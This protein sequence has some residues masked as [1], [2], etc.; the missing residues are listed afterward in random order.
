MGIGP[1]PQNRFAIQLVDGCFNQ[2]S[3]KLVGYVALALEPNTNAVNLSYYD[4]TN[5]DL[6]YAYKEDSS[7]IW[8]TMSIDGSGIGTEIFLATSLAVDN[9]GNRHISYWDSSNE[10]LK[11]AYGPVGTGDISWQLY[12]VDTSGDVGQLA[13]LAV[14]TSGNRHISYHDND[15]EGLKYAYGPA[16]TGDISWQ[17]YKVDSSG[18]TGQFASLALDTGGNRHIAY[19]NAETPDL[20]YAYGPAGN[21]DIS[22][23]IY[24]INSNIDNAYFLSLAVDNSGN[25]H[26]S[27]LDFDLDASN[28]D[29]KYAYGPAGPGNISWQIY[30]LDDTGFAGAFPSIDINP[31]TQKPSI[32]YFKFYDPSLTN[33]ELRIAKQILDTTWEIGVLDISMSVGLNSSSY[34]K[35]DIH[36]DEHLSYT[37]VDNS[38]GASQSFGRVTYG[39][40]PNGLY[41]DACPLFTT[42]GTLE[43]FKEEKPAS[44]VTN[45]T[46][47]SFNQTNPTFQQ[48]FDKSTTIVPPCPSE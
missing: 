37:E 39:L 30:N 6:R 25:R 14:D 13:S 24:N 12:S 2:T 19:T 33:A 1:G 41:G 9:S 7:N 16:G 27:Y 38:Q 32:S 11:Y 48:P 28:F 18:D 44:F 45:H 42:L 3:E 35:F 17:I 31:N 47:F 40:N 15:N 4:S 21:S 10:D 43:V 29:L 26:I 36:G 8:H 23:Q 5:Q 22:W 34:F 20:K 46:D